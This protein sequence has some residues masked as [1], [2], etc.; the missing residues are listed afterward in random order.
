MDTFEKVLS[1]PLLW[2]VCALIAL[3]VA[4]SGK[5]SVSA[6][7][8]L[9]WA[10]WG[11]AVFAVY[12]ALA[13]VGLDSLLKILIVGVVGCSLAIGVVLV[14]RWFDKKESHPA[15]LAEVALEWHDPDPI[16]EG[17]PLSS[18]QLNAKSAT[19]GEPA[20]SPDIGTKL[21]VGSH[22][23]EVTWTPT[24]T[25]KYEATQKVVHIVVNPA[26]PK[27]PPPAHQKPVAALPPPPEDPLV[28]QVRTQLT[29]CDN[30]LKGSSYRQGSNL[31]ELMGMRARL[32]HL[33]DNDPSRKQNENT[34]KYQE[35][36]FSQSELRL[37]NDGVGKDFWT[38]YSE[39]ESFTP[40]QHMPYSEFT[41]RSAPKPEN[42]D[43]IRAAC[44]DMSSMLARYKP[45]KSEVRP[46]MPQ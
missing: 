17:A 36:Q 43:G 15:P 2:G 13:V 44:K 25:T 5:L 16:E 10:A 18:R 29:N 6:A 22:A 28:T 31:N 46:A 3:A 40:P 33:P 27:P 26:A 34:L 8:W 9:M 14:N 12:R 7:G 41:I 45:L 1:H 11:L 20:Y 21:T 30:F 38:I 35:D 4:L 37:W 32:S 23:L 39:L 24:D 42:L 19:E